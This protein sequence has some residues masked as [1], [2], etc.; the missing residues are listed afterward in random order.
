M[1]SLTRALAMDRKPRFVLRVMNALRYLILFE[2]AVGSLAHAGAIGRGTGGLSAQATVG[3]RLFAE[4]RFAQFFQ[5]HC[6]G[7]VNAVLAAGDPSLE[8]IAASSVDGSVVK[9]QAPEKS[10]SCASCHFGAVHGGEPGLPAKGT[11]LF[12][13]FFARSPVSARSDQQLTTVRNTPPLV[14]AL[15]GQ[16]G[17]GGGGGC[18]I[19]MENSRRWRT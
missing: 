11:T 10:L 8:T 19:G 16:G 6:A 9:N 2:L 13:D 12:G 5:T 1:S 15:A 17:A 3:E 7:K 14:A 4:P 18:C